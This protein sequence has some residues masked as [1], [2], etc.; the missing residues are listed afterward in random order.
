MQGGELVR[1]QPRILEVVLV[2]RDPVALD[3]RLARIDRLQHERDPHLPQGVLVP[4]EGT[5][6]GG[7]VLRIAGQALM[8]LVGR[9][10][11]LGV[12]EGGDEIDEPLQP[13]HERRSLRTAW[14][15]NVFCGD[16]A[17]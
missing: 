6:K 3:V 16:D 8:E 12:E 7:L 11:T 5:A 1:R 4:L 2:F 14:L 10:R 17:S 13:V 9:E 15:S